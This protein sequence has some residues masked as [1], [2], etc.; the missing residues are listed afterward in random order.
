MSKLTIS[1]IARMAGVGKATVSRVLNGTGYVS[2]VKRQKIERIIEEHGYVPSAVAQSLARRSTGTVGLVVPEA[3][4]HFFTSI[5]NGITEVIDENHLTLLLCNTTNS[6]EKDLQALQLMKRQRVCGLIFTPAR[7]YQDSPVSDEIR[8][9]LE[10]LNCP[11]VIL[12]RPLPGFTCDT[13]L[14]DNFEGAYMATKVLADAGH[15]KI[16]T[17][18]GDLSLYI[19]RERLRGFQKAIQD[20]GL[21]FGAFSVIDGGFDRSKTYERTKELLKGSELPTAVFVSNN[22]E[23]CGFFRAVSE[24]GLHIP[25]DIAYIGFDNV[26]GV[27]LFG[28]QYSYMDRNVIEM[29]RQTMRLLIERIDHP[30]KPYENVCMPLVPRLYGSEKRVK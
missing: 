17:I 8:R 28:N 9:N 5:L 18:A 24:V 13:L 4:N 25:D 3:D 21:P 23:S 26:E 20:A 16:A 12:D 11:V 14:S 10:D 1:D 15:T 29:G 7:E 19:A 22:Q 2:S 6:L 27:N 30:G